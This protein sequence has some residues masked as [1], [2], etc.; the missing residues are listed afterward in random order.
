[1]KPNLIYK[2]ISAVVLGAL[3]GSYIHHDYVRWAQLGREAFLAHQAARFN[4]YMSPPHPIALTVFA[5]TVMIVGALAI[6]EVLAF[7]LARMSGAMSG[8]QTAR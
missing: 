6:Y 3:F 4:Q 7:A 1:M 2:F 5:S 8:D